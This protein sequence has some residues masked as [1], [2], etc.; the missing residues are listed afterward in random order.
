MAISRQVVPNQHGAPATFGVRH[1]PLRGYPVAA[2]VGKANRTQHG[3]P[4]GGWQVR[5]IFHAVE[6]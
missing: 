3:A 1:D 5:V 2:F 4:E 6:N